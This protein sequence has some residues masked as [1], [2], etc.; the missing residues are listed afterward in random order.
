VQTATTF[1]VFT[2]AGGCDTTV[3]TALRGTTQTLQF[4]QVTDGANT[5]VVQV[6]EGS[7]FV[8]DLEFTQRAVTV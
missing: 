2:V 1:E 4:A 7:F 3:S 5:G 8:V 6:N